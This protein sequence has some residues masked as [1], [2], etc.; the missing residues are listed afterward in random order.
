MDV[1]T[2]NETFCWIGP[3][4]NLTLQMCHMYYVTNLFYPNWI[5]RGSYK[6]R[7]WRKIRILANL[8]KT[9]KVEVAWFMNI[10]CKFRNLDFA[11]FA[12]FREVMKHANAA[13]K[14]AISRLR[15][16]YMCLVNLPTSNLR[17]LSIYS[18]FSCFI[19]SLFCKL[20]FD[21][22]LE[23]RFPSSQNSLFRQQNS[24]GHFGCEYRLT[25]R[26]GLKRRRQKLSCR[27]SFCST[28]RHQRREHSIASQLL[29]GNFPGS[30]FFSSSFTTPIW[31]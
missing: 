10:C 12:C 16:S 13:V 8:K 14:H 1:N 26:N 6:T 5:F 18:I 22:V 9:R 7:K 3:V 30:F 28:W 2:R 19:T 17:V 21:I 31:R 29:Q 24:I 15:E 27:H 25:E 23:Y 20:N 11:S 4:C